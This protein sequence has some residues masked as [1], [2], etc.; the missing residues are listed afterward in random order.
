[1]GRLMTATS[2]GFIGPW[3]EL[4]SGEIDTTS[5]SRVIAA[6][7]G[8]VALCPLCGGERFTGSVD[9]YYRQVMPRLVMLT[10]SNCRVVLS[11]AIEPP[12]RT[13]RALRTAEGTVSTQWTTISRY[14]GDGHTVN[15]NCASCGSCISVPANVTVEIAGVAVPP[16][17]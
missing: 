4:E 3:R 13:R 5:R 12:T 15:L 11:D 16:S 8:G 1:M 17:P 14:P 9:G 7:D 2:P 6:V 10:N